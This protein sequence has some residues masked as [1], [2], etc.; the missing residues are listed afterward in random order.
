MNLAIPA[1]VSIYRGLSRISMA[2]NLT[3][4]EAIFPIHFV[5]GWLGTYF[6]THF[7]HPYD[8]HSLPKMIRISGEKMNRTPDILEA[9][10]LLKSKDLSVMYSNALAKDT[11]MNLIDSHNLSP[12]W[13]A[14]L[15]CLRSGF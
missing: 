9:Q 14:Y 15:I 7:V 2:R 1:L 12:S 8:R 6:K 3:K 4:L 13:R 10:E 5:Y 11:P